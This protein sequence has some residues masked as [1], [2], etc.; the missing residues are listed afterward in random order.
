MPLAYPKSAI[1][2]CRLPA[3]IDK[4]KQNI[5]IKITIRRQQAF[6]TCR[7]WRFLSAA[8]NGRFYLYMLTKQ[9]K[10]KSVGEAE[11][12]LDQNKILVFVDFSGTKVEDLR[13]LKRTLREFGAQLKVIKKNYLESLFK[14][15]RLILIPSSLIL[16]LARFSP[17]KIFRKSPVR[18]INFQGSGEKRI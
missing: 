7:G 1:C 6:K 10:I 5:I 13:K 17:T 8:I 14:T 12:I 15:R 9:Q 18:F 3:G 16:K 4:L 11:K 2:V